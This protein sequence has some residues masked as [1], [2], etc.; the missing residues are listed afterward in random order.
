[1]SQA[2]APSPGKAP[3]KAP[4][5]LNPVAQAVLDLAEQVDEELSGADDKTLGV[6][7]YELEQ[8]D[9]VSSYIS[10]VNTSADF[11]SDLN[12]VLKSPFVAP[13]SYTAALGSDLVAGLKEQ[14]DAFFETFGAYPTF[15]PKVLEAK[16]IDAKFFG[17]CDELAVQVETAYD[18]VTLLLIPE[19]G[20]KKRFTTWLERV[21]P[22]WTS[23]RVQILVTDCTEDPALG[24]VP[25][26][27]IARTQ[28]IVV[29]T[30][31]DDLMMATFDQSVGEIGPEADY[32]KAVMNAL[33]GIKQQD[34]GLARHFSKQA[35]DIAT[36][37]SWT[38]MQVMALIYYGASVPHVEQ[39]ESVKAADQALGLMQGLDPEADPSVP[40]LKY[41]VLMMKGQAYLT[42]KEYAKAAPSYEEAYAL[43]QEMENPLLMLETARM[44][45]FCH[46]HGGDHV[47]AWDWGDKGLTAAS[48]MPADAVPMTTFP[49]LV[50]HLDEVRLRGGDSEARSYRLDRFMSEMMGETWREQIKEMV[51]V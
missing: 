13:E 29:D 33:M 4:G 16:N 1:M 32:Q 15:S 11:S 26:S 21:E 3:G 14:E 41:Q 38:T 44:A 27:Y 51:K 23:P 25:D 18:H 12:I 24:T 10:V 22:R 36:E 6:I 42:H 34:Y 46:Y 2:A 39:Q 50:D 40:K 37:N 7:D 17:M 35:F 30:D 19:T 45:S 49:F 48:D 5:D 28:R 31:M 8:K 9:L 43:S 47:K 20:F